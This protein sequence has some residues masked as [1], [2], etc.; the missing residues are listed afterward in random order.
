MARVGSAFSLYGWDPSGSS[1]SAP[2]SAPGRP[3]SLAAVD[4][5]AI[6]LPLASPRHEVDAAADEL[7]CG[8]F[9]AFVMLR[10]ERTAQER[11][12]GFLHVRRAAVVRFASAERWRWRMQRRTPRRAVARPL[13]VACELHRV[14]LHASDLPSQGFSK[15]ENAYAAP[16]LTLE[17]PA[18]EAALL[19]RPRPR[20]SKA[21]RCAAR[22][23]LRSCVCGDGGRRARYARQETAN[24]I[25]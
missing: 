25:V 4:P 2:C 13:R 14:S 22:R 17:P 3:G 9:S 12:G 8:E 16:S 5:G 10:C 19:R 15:R 11:E 6:A 7:G 21:P 18:R 23:L 20:P 1:F 24:I